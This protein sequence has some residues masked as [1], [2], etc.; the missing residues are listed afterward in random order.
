MHWFST[1]PGLWHRPTWCPNVFFS[2]DLF[3]GTD[4]PLHIY[5]EHMTARACGICDP[6][7]HHPFQSDYGLRLHM[8]QRHHRHLCREC[9]QVGLALP[10][11]LALDALKA[12]D[13]DHCRSCR[14]L[15]A[16]HA[17]CVIPAAIIRACTP[18]A[19][20]CAVLQHSSCLLPGLFRAV[21][22][23]AAMCI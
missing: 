2:H 18:V 16:M 7:A 9:L 13:A 4:Q 11:R 6:H 5:F 15:C 3:P 8:R 22:T 1:T 20:L 21:A 12:P 23:A 19:C 10:A 17:I 14:M